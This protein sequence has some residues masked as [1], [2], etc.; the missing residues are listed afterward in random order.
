MSKKIA[1]PKMDLGVLASLTD[2]LN[3]AEEELLSMDNREHI[4]GIRRLHTAIKTLRNKISTA[5]NEYES[6]T[7]SRV[8][9]K[10]KWHK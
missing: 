5:I 8:P 1:F 3:R 4:T 2:E 7:K 10:P 6:R 9:N